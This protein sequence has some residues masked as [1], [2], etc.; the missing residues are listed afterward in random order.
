MTQF[1]TDPFLM[2]PQFRV[3]AAHSVRIH[4]VRQFVTAEI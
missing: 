3:A 1:C 4:S 2:L